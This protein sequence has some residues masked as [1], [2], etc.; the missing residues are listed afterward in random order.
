MVAVLTSALPDD[1]IRLPILS[2]KLPELD[3]LYSSGKGMAI[4]AFT[5]TLGLDDLAI[6]L[7]NSFL[8]EEIIEPR[9]LA[10]F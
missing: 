6:F 1:Q 4:V 9:K 2:M 7:M 3:L 10:P 8:A 5:L